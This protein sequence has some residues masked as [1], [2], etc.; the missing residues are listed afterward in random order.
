MTEAN[1]RTA[2]TDLGQTDERHCQ[3]AKKGERRPRPMR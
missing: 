2:E 1:T 3:L